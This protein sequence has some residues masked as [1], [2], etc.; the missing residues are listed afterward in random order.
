MRQGEVLASFQYGAQSNEVPT[1]WYLTLPYLLVAGE[2]LPPIAL[3]R[4]WMVEKVYQHFLQETMAIRMSLHPPPT[5]GR[6]RIS[7]D[8]DKN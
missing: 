6:R 4:T 7:M 5:Q 2:E 8:S 1:D 3:C